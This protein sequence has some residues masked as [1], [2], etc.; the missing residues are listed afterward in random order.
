MEHN[1]GKTVHG[2]DNILDCLRSPL[3][4]MDDCF[5]VH[6]SERRKMKTWIVIIQNL[7]VQFETHCD[8][9]IGIEERIDVNYQ[10]NRPKREETIHKV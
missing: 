6:Q 9:N 8:C 3:N 2:I 1:F 7:R 10:N 4:N 5:D